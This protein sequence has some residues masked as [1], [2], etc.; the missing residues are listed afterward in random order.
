MPRIV[1][2]RVE[3]DLHVEEAVRALHV[4]AAH[5]LEAVLDEAHRNAELPREIADEHGVLDAALHAVAA[6]DVDVEVHAHGVAGQ[7]QRTRGLVRELRHLD[8]RP[9]VEDACADVPLRGDA[10][11]LDRHGGAAPPCRA[12]RYPVLGP[13]EGLFDRPPDELAAIEQVRAVRQV[14]ER[15]A[16]GKCFL[17]IDHVRQRFVLDFDQFGRILGERARI[18][19]HGRDPFARVANDVPGEREARHLGCVDADRQRIG[20]RAELLARKNAEHPGRGACRSRI[21]RDDARARVRRGDERDVLHSR[22]R[23]VGDVAPAAGDEARML[24]GAALGTDVAE[25]V[26]FGGAH[27]VFI[28]VA[29][30]CTAS[31]IC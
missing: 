14:N 21:D 7:A 2:S 20:V 18:G 28:R 16:G 4:A 26:F 6:A 29:A 10:E 17:R 5:V 19:D 24:L 25:R 9:D 23:D 30:S 11:G 22:K 12:E 13:G 31:T 8:R 27:L 1:P 15:S 3:R